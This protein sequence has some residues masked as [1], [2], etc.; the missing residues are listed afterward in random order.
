MQAHFSVVGTSSLSSPI[1][2]CIGEMENRLR[3][4][5]NWVGFRRIDRYANET[6]PLRGKYHGARKLMLAYATD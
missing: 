3:I 2:L 5:M 6:F 1:S 4:F